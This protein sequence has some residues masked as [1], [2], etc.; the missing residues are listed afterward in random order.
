M[1]RPE[2]FDDDGYPTEEYCSWLH[3]LADNVKTYPQ[4]F[5]E[6]EEVWWNYDIM[7]QWEK[8]DGREQELRISTG[9]WSGN[10]EVIHHLK[11]TF[12]WFMCWYESR[13]GGHY[14]FRKRVS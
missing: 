12:F 1:D 14:K 9:G 6:L 3:E 8:P 2:V 13:R 10:E 7:H 5:S 11:G 4:V